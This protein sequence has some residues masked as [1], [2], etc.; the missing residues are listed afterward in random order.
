MGTDFFENWTVQV[1]KGILE[2]CV[3][4]ALRG[5]RLYGYD[6]V[7]TLRALD[8]LVIS[9]GTIYPILSRF[10]QEGLVETSLVES[11]AGPA[12]KYYRLTARGERQLDAMQAYWQ[13]IRGGVQTL[14]EEPRP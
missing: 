2:L 1:R 5:R 7:K 13:A 12:R 6:L 14:S 3:L 9:E 11:P 8:G 10:K 4:S